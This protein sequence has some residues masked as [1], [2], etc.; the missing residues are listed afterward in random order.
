MASSAHLSSKNK[1]LV[2][3][4]ASGVGVAKQSSTMNSRIF[5]VSRDI[6]EM[7]I[8]SSFVTYETNKKSRDNFCCCLAKIKG[9]K[10]ALRISVH[11]NLANFGFEL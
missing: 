3:L 10:I 4:L 11:Q 7:Y 1:Y 8:G 9:L 6:T 5:W 2:A